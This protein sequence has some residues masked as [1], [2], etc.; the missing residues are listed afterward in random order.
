MKFSLPMY[1]Y[2]NQVLA[3]LLWKELQLDITNMQLPIEIIMNAMLSSKYTKTKTPL[4][5][6]LLF[7]FF[8][9]FLRL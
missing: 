3:W 5:Q 8:L 4:A 9:L 1:L 6:R 7:P 2:V